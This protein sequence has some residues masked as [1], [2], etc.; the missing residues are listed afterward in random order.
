MKNFDL[1][2]N[3]SDAPKD[4]GNSVAVLLER[5]QEIDPGDMATALCTLEFHNQL[6]GFQIKSP[7]YQFDQTE[8]Y[9]S[10]GLKDEVEKIYLELARHLRSR[11]QGA[12]QLL[13][14]VF[15]LFAKTLASLLQVSRFISNN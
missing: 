10:R 7:H 14:A 11:T 15:E 12:N 9:L 13:D 3:P 2:G 5:L 8:L 4:P 1:D 6:Q